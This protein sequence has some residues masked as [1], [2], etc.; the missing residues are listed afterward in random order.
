[1]LTMRDVTRLPKNPDPY[2]DMAKKAKSCW[3]FTLSIDD[4]NIDFSGLAADVYLIAYLFYN[5]ELK[6]NGRFSAD[7][8]KVF[9]KMPF[10]LTGYLISLAFIVMITDYITYNSFGYTLGIIIFLTAL[11]ADKLA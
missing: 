1:M 6:D 4:V 10:L 7:Y 2:I 9:G 3:K 5:N 11:L 8:F